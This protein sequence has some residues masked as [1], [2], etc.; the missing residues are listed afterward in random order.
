M[1]NCTTKH[2]IYTIY[3]IYIIYILLYYYLN[4]QKQP[5]KSVLKEN[6]YNGILFLAK[7]EARF[8]ISSET[9]APFHVFSSGFYW[10]LLLQISFF[11]ERLRATSSECPSLVLYNPDLI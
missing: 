2:I 10:I 9:K 8:C 7:F 4:V 11:I 3:I 5:S 1:I 6:T